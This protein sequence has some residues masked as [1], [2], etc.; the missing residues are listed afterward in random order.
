MDGRD[1]FGGALELKLGPVD[2]KAF[3]ILS[4]GGDTG[5]SLIVVMSVEFEPPIELGLL[6]TLTGVGGI[7]GVQ[8]AL[9]TDALAAGLHSHAIDNL[10][11][12]AD[13]VAAAPAIVA[14][15][16]SVFPPRRGAIVLGPMLKLGWGRPLVPK[17]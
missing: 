11:F 3:G 15:L 17:L 2:V 16:A 13:P 14:T 5:C 8:R 10:L 1:D 9:D 7:I 4:L 6:V 12:P